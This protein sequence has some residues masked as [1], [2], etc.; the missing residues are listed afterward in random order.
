MANNEKTIQDAVEALEK[1]GITGE[2]LDDMVHEAASQIASAV[3]NGGLHEQ[4]KFL[5][6]NGIDPLVLIE[7]KE[8]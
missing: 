4:V 2:D 3:N 6:E 1:A 5:D 7:A 8:S